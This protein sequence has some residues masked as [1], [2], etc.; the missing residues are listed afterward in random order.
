MDFAIPVDHR[1]KI[2]ESI[3]M[4]EMVIPIVIGALGIVI[5]SLEERLEE[6]EI[7]RRIE[8]IQAIVL[9]WSAWYR[10][11]DVEENCIVY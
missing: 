6:L 5:K 3:K 4:R 10:W 9:L 11:R 7:R 8:T 1:P 2:K